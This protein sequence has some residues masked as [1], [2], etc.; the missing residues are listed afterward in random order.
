M[1]TESKDQ[2]DGVI[3]DLVIT[4]VGGGGLMNGILLG[5]HELGWDNVPLLAMETIGA[6][7]LNACVKA[8][9]WVEL[10]SITRYMQYSIIL[11]PNVCVHTLLSLY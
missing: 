11:M 1:I 9:D 4:A 10:P 7:S 5:L 6:D 2:L 3:P 8:N